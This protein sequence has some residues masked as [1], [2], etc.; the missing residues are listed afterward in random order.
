MSTI[1]L[2]TQSITAQS[3][4]LTLWRDSI[5]TASGRTFT[6]RF[7]IA[8]DTQQEQVITISIQHKE[9]IQLLAAVPHQIVLAPREIRMIPLKGLINN[10]A[11]SL[12]QMIRIRLTDPKGNLLKATAFRLFISPKSQ[13]P[14]TL[15]AQD[16]KLL[17]FGRDESA[18]LSVR[19]VH[20]RAIWEKVWLSVTSL[21]EGVDRSAFPLTVSLA[22]QQ[23]TLL[24]IPVNPTRYWPTTTTE[25][26]ITV[27]D[28]MGSVLGNVMY[29][30]T[31][32]S[33]T[34]RFI[35]EH[36]PTSSGYGVSTALTKLSSD[37]WAREGRIWGSDSVGK[38]RVDFQM[39]YL[40]Y[41]SDQYRQ[42]QNSFLSI[43][44]EKASVH[45]GS[46]YDYHELALLGRGIRLNIDRP[47]HRWTVWGVNTNPNWL[48]QHANAWSG[49]ILSARYDHTL[50]NSPSSMWSLSSSYFN[51][52]TTMRA[53]YLNF[54]SF[55]HYKSGHHSLDVLAG[56]S[57][58]YS[59]NSINRAQT[60][61]WAGL[62]HYTYWGRPFNWELRA[63][64]SSPVY[65]GLQKGATLINA[66]V[67]W[68]PSPATTILSRL[69]HVAYNQLRFISPTDQVRS[70]FSN[71]IAEISL[72]RQ[73]KKMTLGTR[74]YWHAQTDLSNPFSHK[75]DAFRLAS[76]ISY[77]NQS[78]QRLELSYD[79][80][81]F[82]NR[83][84][85]SPLGSIFSQRIM[86]SVVLGSFSLWGYWQ[87]GPYFLGDLRSDQ[88][89]NMMTASLTPMID[90][91]VLSRRLTG[92]AGINYLYDALITGSRFI[93]VGRIQYD[94]TPTLTMRFDGNAMPY[95]QY[96]DQTYSQYR[97][98]LTKRFNNFNVQKRSRLQLSFFED[99][100]G[101]AN[102]D[103]GEPWM[104]SLLVTINQS[105][106][107]TNGKGTIQ[108]Q[109]LPPGTYK[110]MAISTGR[111]GDPVLYNEQLTVAGS[112]TKVIPISRTFR[113]KG[114]LHCQT[115][116]YDNK[117]CQFNR[118]ALAIER[119]NKL[120]TSF[121]PMPDGSFAVHIPPGSYTMTLTDQ[122]R[123]PQAVVKKITFTLTEDG[124]YPT[125]DWTVDAST[126]PIEIK[127]FTTSK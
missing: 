52:S 117:P 49:N 71:T 62:L 65:S 11:D 25:L 116:T 34:K 84:A 98:E 79:M 70:V 104:D 15:F 57:I 36:R 76:S 16:E 60:M 3:I 47:A 4:R 59:Q 121:M 30:L 91:A 40:E 20:N 5:E 97:L 78:R 17:L 10:Q 7:T 120:I 86:S 46:L 22:P 73:I 105:T 50:P 38:A 115:H 41:V 122:G 103:A 1:T 39:H 82:H 80:G 75:A 110:V 107:M 100:N 51:Q 44:T 31:V 94:I 81:L 123:Q 108:Y 19:I 37:H 85:L 64:L 99:T 67:V 13:V 14:V 113:V 27:R 2:F 126:R 77:R 33:A 87:K 42:L 106:L 93:A 102:K 118:F 45:L 53:G 68:Q 56:N 96:S 119:D 109:N 26:V 23:D 54:A 61:G 35:D 124:Q 125:F 58:E 43:R 95:S 24:T 69:N 89:A 92:S 112:V 55:R 29:K 66:Q 6:N 101:N 9:A 28:T 8:N 74:P 48:D 83:N 111:I 12:L 88:P 114:V 72:S 127:R 90:F 21:P 63:Y 32:V 18:R